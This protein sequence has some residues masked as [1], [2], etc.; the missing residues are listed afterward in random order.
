MK[1]TI[2]NEYKN[3]KG[4]RGL[5]SEGVTVLTNLRR[6]I[7]KDFLSMVDLRGTKI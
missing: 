1:I 3:G 2:I 5:V 4:L 7:G 6:E